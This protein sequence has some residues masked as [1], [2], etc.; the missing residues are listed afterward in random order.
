MLV[1]QIAT[2]MVSTC[3]EKTFDM[4]RQSK[5]QDQQGNKHPERHR[6][7]NVRNTDARSELLP[8]DQEL[9]PWD[10]A[11]HPKE[12]AEST[13]IVPSNFRLRVSVF[14]PKRSIPQMMANTPGTPVM[15]GK[16]TT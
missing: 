15:M 5:L 8:F 7:R 4:L 14:S 11:M 13:M 10:N 12:E 2:N 9:A 1:D 3:L 16:A 6:L